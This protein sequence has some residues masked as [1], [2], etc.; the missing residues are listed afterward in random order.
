MKKTLQYLFYTWVA[1]MVIIITVSSAGLLF[2]I[3]TGQIN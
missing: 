2:G 1:V 3:F